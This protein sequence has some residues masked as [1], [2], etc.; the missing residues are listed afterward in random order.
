MTR[1]SL[2]AWR[3]V[4]RW[5][6]LLCTAFLLLLCVTGLPLIFHDEIDAALVPPAPLPA[7]PAGTRPLSLDALVARAVRA[8][9]VP[10]YISF[11]SDRPVVNVTGAPAPEAPA[12]AMRF[13]SL[14]RRTGAVLPPRRVAATAWL[15]RLHT[16][17]LLGEPGELFLGAMGVVFVVALIS[18]VVLYPPFTARRRFGAVRHERRGRTRRL[19][20]HNL[21]GIVTLAWA[22]VVGLTGTANTLAGPVT[23]LWKRRELT[24]IADP[25]ATPPPLAQRASLDAAVARVLAAAP[26]TR[27]QFVAFPGAAYSSAR[28]YAVYLQ[29]GTPLTAR[30]LTPGF[31]DAT[32]GQLDALR[33]MPAYMAALLLAQPLHFG[34]Y[35]A[36]PMKLLWAALDLLAIAVLWTGLRLWFGRRE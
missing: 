12:G 5:T 23:T 6:S 1:R 28:H 36:W 9:E 26:G 34:D 35:A 11:D 30:L 16:D 4:H 25:R 33:P 2:T 13:Q 20:R 8:G 31:V 32:T 29:G 27:V 18:G 17:L 10:L 19:D 22:A 24:T 14:D 3:V 15:L 21:L 7:V